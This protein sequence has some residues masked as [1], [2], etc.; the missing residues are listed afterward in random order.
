MKYIPLR[1]HSVFS[2]GRGVVRAAELANL[3]KKNKLPALAVSDPFSLLGWEK[4]RHQ[5]SLH[6]LKFLP[7]ME[8]K[9]QKLGSLLLFPLSGPGYFSIVRSFNRKM[10]SRMPEVAVIFIPCSNLPGGPANRAAAIRNVIRQVPEK[11]FYLGLEWNSKR[12]LV[13][14]A[15]THKLPLVWAQA[16]KWVTRPRN[17]LVASA[18]FSHRPIPEMLNSGAHPGMV[19]HGPVDDRA[20]LKRWRDAGRQAMNNTFEVASRI[21]FDFGQAKKIENR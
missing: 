8:V 15:A 9:L 7:G 13:D 19:L 12:W 14:L 11:N 21:T 4:F 18:I 6:G 3:M 1:V 2:N 20:I 10:F 16:L 5:A 17:Y